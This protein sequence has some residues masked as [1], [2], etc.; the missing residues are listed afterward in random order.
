MC[1][2]LPVG[3]IHLKLNIA[4]GAK[5]SVCHSVIGYVGGIDS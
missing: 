4:V 2:R 1:A 3:Y 5:W